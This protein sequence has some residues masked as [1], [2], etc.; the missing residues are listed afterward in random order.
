M[1]N[2]SLTFSFFLVVQRRSYT[3]SS[4]NTMRNMPFMSGGSNSLSSKMDV[5]PSIINFQNM[6][7]KSIDIPLVLQAMLENNLISSSPSNTKVST[8]ESKISLMYDLDAVDCTMEALS[9]TFPS[10]FRHRFAMKSCPLS[11]FL[12]R[13]IK[14]G[15]G[16]ECASMIEVKHAMRLGCDPADIVFDSPCKTIDE[17]CFAI[18]NGVMINIDNFDELE[19]VAAVKSK[20]TKTLSKIGIRINPLVGAGENKQLSVSTKTSKF[21]IPLTDENR[22]TLIECFKKYDWLSGLHCHVGSQGCPMTLLASGAKIIVDLADEIDLI[23]GR[24]QIKVLNIG[25]GLS[26]NYDDESVS[27]TLGEYAATLLEEA[28]QLRDE[29]RIILTEFGRCL[30]A[31]VA[32]TLSAVEYVKQN[33]LVRIA[34]IHAGSDLFVR[35]CY[36]PAL[37]P[38]RIEVYHHDG[39]VKK[40]ETVA[41]NI[42]GPLCFAGDV[43][44]RDIQLPKIRQGDFAVIRDTGSNTLSLFSRHCSRPS[45]P[46][47]GYRA[48]EKGYDITLLKPQESADD[49][50]KFWG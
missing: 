16:M 21:G 24:K 1:M 36:A 34:I 42:V 22:K 35:A 12:E 3:M 20:N 44:A 38:H 26:S 5:E 40:E 46:V 41:H 48:S 17:I 7:A 45:P 29:N 14:S 49:V 39:Q 9:K 6:S 10:N 43:I 30:S 31:K 23:V 50:M 27:P 37:S 4:S 13:V 18:D 28:P 47:F 32:W 11:F 25:G 33:D 19:R 2:K 15:H 8:D